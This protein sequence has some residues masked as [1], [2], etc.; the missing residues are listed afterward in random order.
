MAGLTTVALVTVIL[1]VPR[2]DLAH[3]E[4]VRQAAWWSWMLLSGG[5]LAGVLSHALRLGQVLQLLLA[6]FQPFGRIGPAQIRQW[7]PRK[8]ES[9]LPHPGEV[10][11][12]VRRIA[13]VAFDKFFEQVK[14][15]PPG[16]PC[17]RHLF[18]RETLA[19][20]CRHARGQSCQT[21]GS[22]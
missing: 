1:F 11:L 12:A 2:P 19:N 17:G 4:R 8:I 5:I 13:A 15:T 9:P 14:A 6:N 10:G 21:N 20:R 16:Q 22:R 7:Q 3:G 18:S